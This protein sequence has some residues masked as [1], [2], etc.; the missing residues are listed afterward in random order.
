MNVDFEGGIPSNN[1][2]G[3]MPEWAPLNEGEQQQQIELL[4]QQL[5]QQLLLQQQQQQHVLQQQQQL[6]ALQ[7]QQ[8]QQQQALQQQQQQALQQQQQQQALQQQQQQALQQQQPQALQQQQAQ[9]QGPQTIPTQKETEAL[10]Q[11]MKT[12]ADVLYAEAFQLMAQ[13]ADQVLVDAAMTQYEKYLGT[14]RKQVALLRVKFPNSDVLN[15][16]L[17]QGSDKQ[18][19]RDDVSS[20]PSRLTRSSVDVQPRGIKDSDLPMFN[21]GNQPNGAKRGKNN[22][23]YDSAKEWLTN[24]EICV[25]HEDIES[26]WGDWLSYSMDDSQ[27]QQLRGELDQIEVPAGRNRHTWEQVRETILNTFDTPVQKRQRRRALLKCKQQMG[28]SLKS[29][30]RR[31]RTVLHGSEEQP[32]DNPLLVDIFLMNMHIADRTTAEAYLSMKGEW[33]NNVV[34]TFNDIEGLNVLEKEFGGNNNKRKL[35][36]QQTS[37]VVRAKASLD[38]EEE[39][40]TPCWHC[41]KHGVTVDFDTNHKC[42]YYKKKKPSHFNN[43]PASHKGNNNQYSGSSSRHN[44]NGHNGQRYQRSAKRIVNKANKAAKRGNKATK[45][46]HQRNAYSQAVMDQDA[47]IDAERKAL[48]QSSGRV[49]RNAFYSHDHDEELTPASESQLYG[50]NDEDG[51]PSEDE[52]MDEASQCKHA[53]MANKHNP[54]ISDEILIPITLQNQQVLALLDSGATFSSIDVN[55][56]DR[57][58]WGINKAEG[59][60]H[61]ADNNHVV[62]RMGITDRLKVR[63]NKRERMHEFEVMHLA[64]GHAVSI[65]TDL[66]PHFGIGY[67]GL[68]STWDDVEH[69]Q[70]KEEEKPLP[71]PNASPAGTK[72]EHAA[73]LETLQPLLAANKA[74]PPNAFCTLPQAVVHLDTPQNQTVYRPQYAIAHAHRPLVH[75]TITKWLADGIIKESPPDVRG[76]WNNPL[77]LAPKKDEKGNKTK[78]RL[79]LDPRAL[80][81]LLPDD[82]FYIPHIDEIFEK[83]GQ[84]NVFTTLD[85]TQAFHR[86]PIYKP[87][88]VKTSFTNIVDGR[89]Y[90]FVSMPFGIKSTSSKFQRCMNVLLNGLPF[91][92]AYVDDVVIFSKNLDEHTHHVADIIQRLTTVNLAL[93]VDKCSFGMRS[94]HLLGF[95]ISEGGR[96]SLDPRKV[97]NTQQWPRPQTGK[98]IERFLGVVNYFRTHIPKAALLTSPLDA[99]RKTPDLQKVWKTCHEHAFQN[100]KKALRHAPVLYQPDFRR[101]FLVATDASNSGI[102]AVLYQL[103]DN[104]NKRHISFMARSLKP[105]EKNYGIT[106][107]E[108]LAVIFALNRFHIYL[109][110]NKF[111][112]YTDHKALVYLHTQKELNPML[113]KWLD[114]ILDYNFEIIHLRGIDNILPDHLSRLFPDDQRLGEGNNKDR[115]KHNA[116]NK[117]DATPT[118]AARAAQIQNDTIE[119]AAEDRLQLIHESHLLGHFGAEAI[120]KDLH[121]QGFHWANMKKDAIRVTKSCPPCQRFTIVRHGY[122]PLRPIDSTIPGDHWS[123]DLAGPLQETPRGNK[124]LLI[125]VDVCTRFCLL[126]PIPD[127]TATTIVKQLV[128][129]FTTFGI[130]RIVQSDNGPEFSN[131]LMDLF[132]QT[133]GFDH[134]LITP[135]HPQANGSAERW[136]QT[137]VS[138]LKKLME[139]AIEDWDLYVPATQLSLNVKVSERHNTRPFALMFARNLNAFT[140]YRQDGIKRSMSAEEMS[141]V[142]KL[143]EE[144]VFPA[145][146]ERTRK[147]NNARKEKFD[148]SNKIVE[149]QPG[150]P[151]M[152]RIHPSKKQGKLDAN[153]EGPYIVERKTKGGSY[154]LKDLDDAI[155]KRDY[156]PHELKLAAI[157]L[158]ELQEKRYVVDRIIDHKTDKRHKHLYRVRWK[159]YPPN[160]DTWEP[161]THFDD[162]GTIVKYWRHLK[163]NPPSNLQ[164]RKHDNMAQRP[165]SKRVA[166]RKS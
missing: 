52:H 150:D 108:L 46:H 121:K 44:N 156:T 119:P 159:G 166:T 116:K 42:P 98:D 113:V 125:M 132:A 104:G 40:P 71:T 102:G 29:F 61:L 117:D 85:L 55:F 111:R 138:G 3:L 4:Q 54:H 51:M 86:L 120:V 72:T 32:E 69:E 115:L 60:I 33:P 157:P 79:C 161:A 129:A 75:E 45:A 8:Q 141:K 56:C 123:I 19:S 112:L 13:D 95:C 105:A 110:G 78:F 57:M 59:E 164:K 28:E 137:A 6:E 134:R 49:A 80:N 84:A 63:Y 1:I 73:F 103:D 91:A 83:I 82:W 163:K 48:Q 165:P 126:K 114:R 128:D 30:V 151:V 37:R 53:R 68:V 87:D 143:M 9:Q 27:I 17:D 16:I 127:N 76:K 12:R 149:F 99:L 41:A 142:A 133:A 136:V 20:Q 131:E 106:K 139:G 50:D 122:N 130:P 21:I 10:A 58:N 154:R 90:C 70:E 148:K 26:K 145:I 14:M 97:A 2:P 109:W 155:E 43:K 22:K 77:T 152:I 135:Y 64:R 107:K 153:Y 5:E 18:T 47:V 25:R 7:Q 67:T 118:I 162:V 158:E 89:S 34:K 11:K 81:Q 31:F 101:P 96:K 100:I 15:E 88:Q 38:N 124:Y 144:V 65:G 140:D 39:E 146:N 74:I 160:E 23:L 35:L 93:N 92:A 24:F 147:V 62:K 94:V 36:E 66:M